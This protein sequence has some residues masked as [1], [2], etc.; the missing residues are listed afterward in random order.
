MHDCSMNSC[1]VQ[2]LE[3]D[4]HTG[5]RR[6]HRR[7]MHTQETDTPEALH[8][9]AHQRLLQLQQYANCLHRR[10]THTHQGEDDACHVC[11]AAGKRPVQSTHIRSHECVFRAAGILEGQLLAPAQ[12]SILFIYMATTS[13]LGSSHGPNTA[14]LPLPSTWSIPCIATHRQCPRAAG[15]SFALWCGTCCCACIVFDSLTLF[16]ELPF[17]MQ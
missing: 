17:A 8:Q 6:T 3:T 4:A 11:K 7:P 16:F 14:L 2:T 1:K 5:D 9:Q 15:L 12:S 13:A 10:Q